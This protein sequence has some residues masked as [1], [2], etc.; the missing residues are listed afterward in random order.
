MKI[1]SEL[2]GDF[3][4]ATSKRKATYNFSNVVD[5]L[6]MKITHVIRGDDH[7]TNAFKQIL[8]F[9]A[10]GSSPPIF[11]HVPLILGDNKEKLS[12][13]HGAVG[14]LE[15]KKKGYYSEP[16]VNHL[17]LLGWSPKDE[18]EVIS[19]GKLEKSFKEIS[20]A[21]SPAVFDYERLNYLNGLY[22]R[23]LPEERVLADFREVLTAAEMDLTHPKADEILLS[24][25]K[26]M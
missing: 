10:L 15:F 17:A 22:L 24:L 12:K 7:L 16:L 21:K 19:R 9:E 11:A 6:S 1:A 14:V 13:R 25:K 20:F 23:N 4:V 26:P 2:L 18:E 8:L 3:I 5:D